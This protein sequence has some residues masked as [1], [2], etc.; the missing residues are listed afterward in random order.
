M[1]FCGHNKVEGVSYETKTWQQTGNEFI[2]EWM[3]NWQ[4]EPPTIREKEIC[5]FFL[6]VSLWQE[7]NLTTTLRPPLTSQVDLIRRFFQVRS[8]AK[9]WERGC[10]TPRRMRKRKK[11]GKWSPTLFC[12]IM[13]G[14]DSTTCSALRGFLFGFR[15][16]ARHDVSA[17]NKG[18]PSK[19]Q[20]TT[21][22]LD[23]HAK[24][25]HHLL[26]THK[27]WRAAM[28]KNSSF[29]R[30]KIFCRAAAL[31]LGITAARMQRKKPISNK[32]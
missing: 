7:S 18:G 2:A 3:T 21:P 19:P 32:C 29:Y 5:L 31:H 22:N 10:W 26:I 8:S 11:D 23:L 27:K 9:E 25:H 4:V 28:G 17:P 15:H 6:F 1:T 24:I 13:H 30:Q 16:N 14:G 20:A 12:A